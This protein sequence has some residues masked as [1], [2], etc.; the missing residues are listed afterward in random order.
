MNRT[1]SVIVL[2]GTQVRQFVVSQ[3]GVR[4][5]LWTGLFLVSL[6]GWFLRDYVALQ[7]QKVQEI[8]AKAQAQRENV[9]GLRG[10]TK[11]VQELLSRWKGFQE[12]IQ[13]SLPRRSRASSEGQPE[14][15]ELQEILGALQSELNQMI[16]SFPSD[17][18]VQG[19]VVSGVG[20]RSSPWTGKNEFHPGLDI[21]DPVGTPVLASGDA[22]VEWV[23]ERG[24]RGQTVILDHGQ[25]INTLYA[26]LS[27]I[28]VSEG[29]RVRKGQRIA[30]VGNSGRST[31]PHLHYE[32]MVN[33]IPIDPRKRLINPTPGE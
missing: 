33:G 26:H 30:L 27:E 32:V 13:A 6:G 11:E 23:G 2:R 21:A 12:R 25:E 31:G 10:R 3:S 14:D 15:E 7:K 1:Y 17:W 29:D 24:G 28:F 9:S 22:V 18:P 19:R 8:I 4:L 20:L 5:L 16:S